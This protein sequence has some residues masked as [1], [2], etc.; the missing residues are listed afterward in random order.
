M[1]VGR[2]R[3]E[4]V[5]T[6]LASA[7][8]RERHRA[9]P[10]RRHVD[11]AVVQG[12]LGIPVF[13]AWLLDCLGALVIGHLV[14]VTAQS[15]A[16][17]TEHLSVSQVVL[18]RAKR[19]PIHPRSS[20]CRPGAQTPT[21]SRACLLDGPA[22]SWAALGEDDVLRWKAGRMARE[23]GLA[24]EARR[25]SL[26]DTVRNIKE[27]RWTSRRPSCPGNVVDSSSSSLP[28][29]AALDCR[30]FP[31]SWIPPRLPACRSLPCAS[32]WHPTP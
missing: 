10:I 21:H 15:I 1:E 23:E 6:V 22:M 9:G 27:V 28:L 20:S 31:A 17:V 14:N 8:L 32:R 29:G 18:L 19:R 2:K 7:W 30:S 16:G 4:I 13:A 25:R 3:C 12:F 11:G 24:L 26:E 5:L